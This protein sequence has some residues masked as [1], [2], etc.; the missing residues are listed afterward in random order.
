MEEVA[1]QIENKREEGIEDEVPS[2]L[3]LRI[4]SSFPPLHGERTCHV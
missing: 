2:S 3:G 4:C 1:F